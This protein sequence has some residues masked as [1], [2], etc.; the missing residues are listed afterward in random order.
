MQLSDMFCCDIHSKII[1][2]K[3]RFFCSVKEKED[4]KNLYK[5]LHRNVEQP[6][7]VSI[8]LDL[9]EEVFVKYADI[10]AKRYED[11]MA[12]QQRKHAERSQRL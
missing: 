7:K 5:N 10:E 9:P 3:I 4:A 12:E 11:Y 2:P 6:L 1:P 8:F